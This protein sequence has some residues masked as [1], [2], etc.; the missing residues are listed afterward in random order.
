MIDELCH[1]FPHLKDR[2]AYAN[3]PAWQA[4]LQTDYKHRVMKK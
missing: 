2:D 3:T 4:A 1:R